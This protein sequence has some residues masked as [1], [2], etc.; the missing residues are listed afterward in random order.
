LVKPGR[1][2]TAITYPGTRGVGHQWA[3]LPDVAEV[4]VQLVKRDTALESFSTF[5]MDGHWDRDGTQM[6]EA[7]RRVLNTPRLHASRSG[8]S[9]GRWCR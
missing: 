8:L 1:P 5:H 3:Y 2:V 7:I 6:I 4:M 9:P